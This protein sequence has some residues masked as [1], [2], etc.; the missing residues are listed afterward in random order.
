VWSPPALDPDFSPLGD[1]VLEHVVALSFPGV[2]ARLARWVAVG[3]RLLSGR[4]AAMDRH[5]AECARQINAGRFDVLLAHPCAYYRVTAIARHVNVPTVLYLQEPY[6]AMYEAQPRLPWVAPPDPPRL[7]WLSPRHLA[8]AAADWWTTQSL[9]VQAR[10]EV[11]NASAFGLILVNSRFSRES[12][13]RA[14]GLE[15]KVCY[16]G[17]DTELFRPQGR[18]RERFVMSLGSVSAGKGVDRAISALATI[19]KGHRPPLVWVGN[20]ADPR[21]RADMERLANSRGVALRV[22]VRPDDRAVIDLLNRAALLVYAPRLEPFGFAPLE[23]NACET[24]V[25]AIAEGGVR[26]SVCDGVNGLLVDDADPAALGRAIRALLDDPARARALGRQAR[27]HVVQS[28]SWEAAVARL[29]AH[30]VT[31][32]RRQAGADPSCSS[33]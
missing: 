8:A 16:L 4:I 20:A 2:T 1:D 25:V 18:P 19:P 7:W 28:W 30:L 29:E 11:D 9:R 23:A 27:A 5:C 6:R 12:V 24:P 17:A 15:A 13:L 33:S 22:H 10:E 21:Y 31:A 14:Y 32:A 3:E 26:E